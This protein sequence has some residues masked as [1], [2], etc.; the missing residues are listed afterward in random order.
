MA[1]RIADLD[2]RGV[3]DGIGQ[4]EISSVEATEAYLGRIAAP[5]VS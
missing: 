5:A 3:S 1:V 4:R 2:L